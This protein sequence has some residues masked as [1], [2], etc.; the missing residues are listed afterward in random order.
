MIFKCYGLDL[1]SMIL[2]FGAML[3]LGNK[4]K[5]GFIFF[6]LANITMIAVSYFMLQ[7]FALI[8]GNTIFLITNT[9]GVIKWNADKKRNQF[10]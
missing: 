10:V 7:S 9:R 5:W 4:I 8:V 1:L 3:L 2:S 6:V